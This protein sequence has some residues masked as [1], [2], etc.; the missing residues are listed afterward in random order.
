MYAGAD[1]IIRADVSVSVGGEDGAVGGMNGGESMESPNGAVA[2]YSKTFSVLV[3]SLSKY[4]DVMEQV[5]VK[6]GIGAEMKIRMFEL[7]N[8]KIF[9]FINPNNAVPP[10]MTGSHDCG[11]EL[12]AEPVPG[13]ET[14][15]ML[16][17]EYEL[18]T[19]LH[20]AKDKRV[21]RD[22]IT[23]NTGVYVIFMRGERR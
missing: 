19:V 6:L 8:S 7:K 11:A 2:G 18:M 12:R 5:R 9:R 4:Q 16:G 10:L 20:L 17:K 21:W 1:A 14:E 15:E 23:V 13:N 22:G 3:P